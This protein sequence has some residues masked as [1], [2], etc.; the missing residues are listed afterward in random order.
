[1]EIS[2]NN[3]DCQQRMFQNVDKGKMEKNYVKETLIKQAY[4]NESQLKEI[5]LNKN[6][7]LEVFNELEHSILVNTEK[8]KLNKIIKYILKHYD[9][10]VI[11]SLLD[12]LEPVTIFYSV[13]D[14][15]SKDKINTYNELL[16]LN[17][18]LSQQQKELIIQEVQ[19]TY[20]TYR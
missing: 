6:N 3:L 17:V 10:T 15:N 7:N 18:S 2:S 12:I 14:S 16:Q 4:T 11:R 13:R 19:G 5:L 1:S 20:V 8:P 9:Y